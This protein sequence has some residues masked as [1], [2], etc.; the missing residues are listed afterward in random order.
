[1]KKHNTF[2]VVLV[3]LLVLML[4]TWILP[5]AYYSGSYVDQGR[6]QMG[7]F[8]LFNYPVTA[9]SYFGYIAAFIL[10]V[11]GFYGVLN[12][13]GAYRTMLD[14]LRS[15]F[16]GK[17]VVVLS[18]MMVIIALLTSICG[19]QLGLIIFYPMLVSL[20]LLM[21][22]DKIVAALAIV[23]S[24][25]M[26]M[27]G[28]TF[29]YNNTG[30]FSSILG[31]EFTNGMLPKCIVLFLGVVLLIVNTVLYIRK[32]QKSEKKAKV[33]KVTAKEEKKP[34]KT[35]KAKSSKNTKAA[36]KEE[37]VVVV[38]AEDS[39]EDLY[40]P[41]IVAGKKHIVWPLAIVLSIIFI[42]LVLAFISWSGA[43][44]LN[45]MDDATT[46]VTG[47]E[48]FGFALFGK[49]LGTVNAFGSWT[50]VDMVVVL[51]VFMFI[52]AL[53]YKVKFDEV[54][55]GFVQGAKR[56]LGPA[57]IAIMIYTI[58]VITTYH[59]FQLVIYKAILGITDGFNVF[60]TF[61]VAI[62]SA[63]FNGD[64]AYAFQSS[65]PYLSSLVTNADNYP[66][67]AVVYQA[68]YGLTM[69]VAPTSLILMGMLSYLKIPYSKWFKA[70]WKLVLELLVV[71][72]I[73]FTILILI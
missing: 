29:G 4:L 60:T 39:E 62:L 48:V 20:I 28:T 43:F 5:A 50:L 58:L 35:T 31:T 49:L 65:L 40:V 41:T 44:G 46:A 73:V 24:T 3:T 67:M 66:I 8:D 7:L 52:L 45:A 19:L 33:K 36:V 69:L 1:M 72:L 13:I 14:K 61:I 12:K 22:F 57:V 27:L 18:I 68:A 54:L 56:A 21:G 53:I 32:Q 37:E 2:K 15:A 16:K 42:I 59:P 55:D 30:I 34:A 47:F 17:E 10:A 51:M 70:I 11:G 6:V 23:G 71:L 25:M 63:F 38:T 64:I 9:V 26:G